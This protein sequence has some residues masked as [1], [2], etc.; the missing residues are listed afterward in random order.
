MQWHNER[1]QL[2][3]RNDLERLQQRI[4]T[5]TERRAGRDLL[6]LEIDGQLGLDDHQQLEQTLSQLRT[7]LLHLRVRGHAAGDRK[8]PNSAHFWIAPMPH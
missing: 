5:L 8:P 1:I 7:R 4:T 2:R 6:R 3:G